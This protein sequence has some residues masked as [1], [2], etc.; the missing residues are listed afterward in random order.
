MFKIFSF[1]LHNF[2]SSIVVN[3]N[4]VPGDKSAFRP[5]GIRIGTPALTTRSFIEK[6]M[7]RVGD[8]IDQSI[9]LTI[10]MVTALGKG[11]TLKGFKEA[12]EQDEWKTK[13][14][15][16]RDQVEEFALQFPMPGPPPLE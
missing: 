7:E 5:G 16:I 15:T 2:I 10:E 14:S 3:R 13:I 1:H 8:L 12:L 9:K 11:G 6:D 4:T